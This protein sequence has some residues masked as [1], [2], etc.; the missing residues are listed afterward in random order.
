MHFKAIF[1]RTKAS[2]GADLN[3]QWYRV[4]NVMLWSYPADL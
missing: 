1:D 2:K 3:M 4:P